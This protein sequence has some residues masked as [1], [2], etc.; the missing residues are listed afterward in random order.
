[1]GATMPGRTGHQDVAAAAV[2][3]QLQ[4]R[5]VSAATGQLRVQVE[6]EYTTKGL[7]IVAR[8]RGV[9]TSATSRVST[10]ID[11][12]WEIPGEVFD[13]LATKLLLLKP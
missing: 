5:G 11:R 7:L 8:W 3:E 13:T 6:R 1:M 9:E 10:P 2:L 4:K 12:W